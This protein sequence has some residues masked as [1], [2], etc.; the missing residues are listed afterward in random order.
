MLHLLIYL[1]LNQEYSYL[2]FSDN[3]QRFNKM[4]KTQQ[5]SEDPN[6]YQQFFRFNVFLLRIIG[7]L[8][9][10]DL[11]PQLKI[12]YKMY[13]AVLLAII[14]VCLISQAIAMIKIGGENFVMVAETFCVFSGV[15]IGFSDIVFFLSKRKKILELMRMIHQDFITK[16][17]YKYTHIPLEAQKS[18]IKSGVI[19]SSL[20]LLL[21]SSAIL[22][23]LFHIT[24]F[25][26]NR[27][28]PLKEDSWRKMPFVLWSPFDVNEISGR[29]IVL[30]FQ[31]CLSGAVLISALAVDLTCLALM[32]QVTAQFR[33][34]IA[35]L[36]NM[37][38]EFNEWKMERLTL[39]KE[40][41]NLQNE[42][43]EEWYRN[44]L[45]ECIEHHQAILQ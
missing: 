6:E 37:E 7:L 13:S 8:P 40:S 23:S 19:K 34:L 20:S 26:I 42:E 41:E 32:N 22:T 35:L 45:K 36:D 5:T 27:E 12:L 38:E 25:D 2:N 14:T 3:S 31:V 28:S 30:V 21:G 16:T 15:I 10:E 11:K 17:K 24:E 9:P 33:Y 44:Y 43:D 29:I 1:S 39:Y 4:E 18:L